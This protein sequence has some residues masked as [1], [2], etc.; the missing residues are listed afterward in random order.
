MA[1]TT[2]RT[3]VTSEVVTAA[4]MN[5]HVKANLDAVEALLG[6][7]VATAVRAP[8]GS[9]GTPG[10]SFAGDTDVGLYYFATGI[11]VSVAGAGQV[12]FQDGGVYPVTDNDIDLGS[13]ALS[14]KA[15]YTFDVYSEAGILALDTSKCWTANTDNPTIGAD[16]TPPTMGAGAV[17]QGWTTKYNGW[18]YWHFYISV[19][20]AGYGDGTGD[21][22]LALPYTPNAN[23]SSGTLFGMAWAKDATGGQPYYLMACELDQTNDRIYFIQETSSARCDASANVPFAWDQNDVLTGFVFYWLA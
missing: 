23:Y 3:W 9:A 10:Y 22:Y 19:G 21:W 17:L 18:C 2:P 7:G 5:A 14:F 12:T 1:W 6:T 13:A 8:S 20:G 16:T 15:V 11:G 4:I